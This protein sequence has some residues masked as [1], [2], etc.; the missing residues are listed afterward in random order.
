MEG[1][2]RTH[3]IPPGKSHAGT[4]VHIC[5]DAAAV[6][7][8]VCDLV[9]SACRAAADQRGYAALAVPG[10]SVLK[11]LGGLTDQVSAATPASPT[12]SVLSSTPLLTTAPLP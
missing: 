1:V 12:T 3:V 8:V 10:G 9:S 4:T 5:R 11:M 7:D 2:I 6:S